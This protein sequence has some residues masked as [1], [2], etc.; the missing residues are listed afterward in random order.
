VT[1]TPLRDAALEQLQRRHLMRF[2][3]LVAATGTTPASLQ[4][5]I[6]AGEPL[7]GVL[8]DPPVVVFERFA[9]AASPHPEP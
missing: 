7:F 9:G 3:E 4:R 6:T 1:R 5:L 8:G 2:A